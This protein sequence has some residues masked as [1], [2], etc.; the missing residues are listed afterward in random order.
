MRT[1]PGLVFGDLLEPTWHFRELGTAIAQVAAAYVYVRAIGPRSFLVA[2][3]LRDGSWSPRLLRLRAYDLDG[4]RV[5][6]SLNRAGF[7]E[8][9]PVLRALGE[10]R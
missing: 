6:G 4:L 7:R 9:G 1:L 8:L 10:P 5:L 2:V 3:L